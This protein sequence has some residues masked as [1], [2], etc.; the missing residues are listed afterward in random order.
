MIVGTLKC[1]DKV[2]E[3]Q[4]DGMVRHNIK[5]GLKVLVCVMEYYI[6]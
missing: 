3:F 6:I 4:A 1:R 2:P 5:I